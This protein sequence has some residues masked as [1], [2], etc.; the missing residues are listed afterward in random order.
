MKLP[1]T[2]PLGAL[3][4]RLGCSDATVIMKLGRNFAKVRAAV[5]GALVR[6]RAATDEAP[7]ESVVSGLQ[8]ALA[9]LL[10]EANDS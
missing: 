6:A 7:L 5:E 3:V 8:R 4:E 2:L 10:A 9:A 1:G